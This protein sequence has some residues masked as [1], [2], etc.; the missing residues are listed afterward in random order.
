M[1]L[2]REMLMGMFRH[3]LT[4]AGGVFVAKG[5]FDAETLTAIVGAVSTLVGAGM[6]IYDKR[7]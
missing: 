7:A 2:N 4:Y 5:Y 1:N 3:F 6:S